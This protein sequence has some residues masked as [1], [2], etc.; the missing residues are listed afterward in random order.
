MTAGSVSV[1]LPDNYFGA[2]SGGTAYPK[3]K[4]SATLELTKARPRLKTIIRD[5]RI[6]IVPAK[7]NVIP[8]RGQDQQSS[9]I[10]TIS[11]SDVLK[12][13]LIHI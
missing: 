5:K 2:L 13:S 12:L 1:T 3:L 6:V 10:K 11:Y 8:L 9:E 4:L 7:D